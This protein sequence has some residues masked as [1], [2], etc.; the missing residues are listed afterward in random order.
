MDPPTGGESAAD[1]ETLRREEED[2]VSRF[3]F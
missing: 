3:R 2:Q 1:C